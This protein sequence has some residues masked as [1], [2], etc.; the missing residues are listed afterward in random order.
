MRVQIDLGIGKRT[1]ELFNAVGGAFFGQIEG[2]KFRVV[3]SRA[4]RPS[5]SR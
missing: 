2:E 3:T 1:G 4:F 5:I